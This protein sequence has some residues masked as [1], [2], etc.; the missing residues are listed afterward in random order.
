MTLSV[1]SSDLDTFLNLDSTINAARAD[2]LIELAT[3][4]CVS[5]IDPVPDGAKRIILSAAGR[6][7][8][9]PD[10]VEAHTIGPELVTYGT[11]LGGL[12]LTKAEIADLKRMGGVG[13]AFSVDPTP[14]D[15]F[16]SIYPWD[17]NIWGPYGVWQE[18]A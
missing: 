6:A 13:G 17:E 5:Y 16:S 14:D 11:T 15:A 10:G 2:L 12:Y 9:N 4:M 8:S 1:T 3:D 18:L 7:Y